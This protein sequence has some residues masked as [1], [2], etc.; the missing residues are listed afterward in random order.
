[1]TPFPAARGGNGPCSASS[2]PRPVAAGAVL[3]GTAASTPLTAPEPSG[4]TRIRRA[5]GREGHSRLVPDEPRHDELHP[6]ADDDGLPTHVRRPR[7]GPEDPTVT[8]AR[9]GQRMLDI[10][11]DLAADAGQMLIAP[12]RAECTTERMSSHSDVASDAD[13]TAEEHAAA[14]GWSTCCAVPRIVR[15]RS[16]RSSLPT[17]RSCAGCSPNAAST[18][19]R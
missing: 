18:P 3:A 15:P 9:R 13:G 6:E 1:M 4:Q 12:R 10:V 17:G 11:T 2:V 19:D 14:R 16:P 5:L 8:H 7:P